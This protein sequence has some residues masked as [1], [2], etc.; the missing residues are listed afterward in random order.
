MT[1]LLALLALAIFPINASAAPRQVPAG[2]VDYTMADVTQSAGTGHTF[3]YVKLD[4]YKYCKDS[5]GTER[6]LT[7]SGLI[8]NADI[9]PS[10]AVAYSKLDLSGSIVNA[11][12]NASAAIVDT[13]LAT[14][15]TAGKVANSATTA[16]SSAGNDTIVSRDSS[17]DFVAGKI[18]HEEEMLAK[19]IS[20]PS[21]PAS[22]YVALYAKNDDKIYKKTSAGVESE[23]GSG[24]GGG[25]GINLV[26]FDTSGN[27]YS[28]TKTD[29][30]N[31]DATVGDWAAYADAAGTS[32]VDMTG[33]S[34]GT[35]CTRDTADT[36]VLNGTGQL[37]M[38]LGSGSSRQGEGC[39]L[40][41]NVPAAYRGKN[42]T[43]TFPFRITG[44]IA[45]DELKV[46]AY[47]VTNSLLA[48]PYRKV[49]LL[50]STGTAV[51]VIPTATN[52]AQVRI[53]IHVA[54]TAT[55]ALSLVADD[56]QLSPTITAQ[57][58]AGS[59][60]T[61]YTPG[62]NSTSNVAYNQASWQRIG[63]RI[64]I[65]GSIRWSGTGSGS[66]QVSLPSGLTADLTKLHN[67]S[68]A[69]T[70]PMDPGNAVWLDAGNALFTLYPR[71]DKS[72]PTRFTFVDSSGSEF[73]QGSTANNDQV[74]YE[75]SMPIVG[76]SSNVSMGESSSFWAS[77]ILAN[78]T[79]V[80]AEPA[81]LGEYRC[82]YKA[83]SSQDYTGWTDTDPSASPSIA[84]GLRIYADAYNAAGSSGEC[85]AYE[86][87]V[88]KNKSV[89]NMRAW[90]TSARAQPVIPSYYSTGT[91]AFGLFSYY[92]PTSGVVFVS[93]G[94]HNGSNTSAA[95]GWRYTGAQPTDGY[96][97]FQVSENALAV[98]IDA[99]NSHIAF[100]GSDDAYGST[101]TRVP[102]YDDLVEN[103]GTAFT[104]NYGS[105]DDVS[106]TVV[107]VLED[108]HY[109]SIVRMARASGSGTN[110]YGIGIDSSAS[111][112][113]SIEGAAL[114]NRFAS[115]YQSM[116]VA[117]GM[118]QLSGCRRLRAGQTLRVHTD[119]LTMDT[120][121][122]SATWE[123]WK[124]AN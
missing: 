80:T 121:D 41:V 106:G 34:P 111:Q 9:S 29:N 84:D 4:G 70:A 64:L 50:G 12:I 5:S 46:S 38:D 51:A 61:V 36:P 92:D 43:L 97:D 79:R 88:G 87:F 14:I 110:Q 2:Y 55:T 35:T 81:K 8:V 107:T 82:K 89:L 37:K 98:G 78:G 112:T 56:F 109:C 48:D 117:G 13:K 18:Q 3:C 103:V 74:Q 57:G 6:K 90:A 77:Q 32:A 47:D 58:M 60:S 93:A 42:L 76:W 52:S 115:A 101:G 45:E 44:T 62:L 40:L 122:A 94:S 102:E 28:P 27:N 15:S 10:A 83:S 16:T 119:G 86:I 53:G 20:T 66:L 116:T 118:T 7:Y 63:D 96:F 11:D 68:G 54:R 69:G 67:D 114:A 21:S 39:S 26:T 105:G 120:A 85:N 23:I 24:G 65:K 108:G 73:S 72:T 31:L 113:T 49:K 104:S 19:H 30:F 59:D 91:L 71:V 1:K 33:G 95:I 17:G 22:G 100:K 99:V 124:I 123:V 75:I 25:S